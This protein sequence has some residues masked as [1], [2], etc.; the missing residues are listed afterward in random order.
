MS[1]LPNCHFA[2]LQSKT[3]CIFQQFTF[4][5]ISLTHTILQC[6]LGNSKDGT[7]NSKGTDYLVGYSAKKLWSIIREKPSKP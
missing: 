4:L 7:E 1:H 3:R 2:S 6:L 5:L